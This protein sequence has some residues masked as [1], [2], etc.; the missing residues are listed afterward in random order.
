MTVKHL[1][2][3]VLPVQSVVPPAGFLF[4]CFCPEATADPL[5]VWVKTV[6]TSWFWE[7]ECS[8]PPCCCL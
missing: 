3:V 5:S 1:N 2:A 6:V 7:C 4:H 8:L